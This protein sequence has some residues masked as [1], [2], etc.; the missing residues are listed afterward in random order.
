MYHLTHIP[1][2][3]LNTSYFDI[4]DVQ[5][6]MDKQYEV[7][8]YIYTSYLSIHLYHILSHVHTWNFPMHLFKWSDS[9]NDVQVARE[10]GETRPVAQGDDP[11][12]HLGR[13]TR[14]PP[15]LR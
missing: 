4:K 5:K 12:S 3:Q 15:F 1:M 13:G 6:Y 10:A 8:I 11:L 14:S 9:G 2:I 7:Y